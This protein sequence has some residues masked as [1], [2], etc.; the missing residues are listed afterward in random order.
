LTPAIGE[1]IWKGDMEKGSVKGKKG[2]LHPIHIY[3][4]FGDFLITIE[5]SSFWGTS[6]SF[7]RFGAPLTPAIGEGIWKGNMGKG[8]VKGRK[9]GFT[10]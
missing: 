3:I 5:L 4:P 2:R 10:L 1:G 9:G 8:S 7:L 6:L